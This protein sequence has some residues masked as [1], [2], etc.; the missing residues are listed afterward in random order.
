MGKSNKGK[1]WDVPMDMT[2]GFQWEDWSKETMEKNKD[3]GDWRLNRA[4][5]NMRTRMKKRIWPPQ[6]RNE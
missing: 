6:R 2:D 5:K 4:V 3:D 1:P